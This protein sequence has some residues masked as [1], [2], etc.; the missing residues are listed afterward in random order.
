MTKSKAPVSATPKGKDPCHCSRPN[1][2]H[3]RNLHDPC[4]LCA[5]PYFRPLDRV[6]AKRYATRETD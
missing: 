4:S 5:C 2:V 3:P 1:E 6:K